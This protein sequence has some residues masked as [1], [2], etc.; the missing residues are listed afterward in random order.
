MV[1]DPYE[2]DPSKI[3]VND[4]YADLPFYGRYF[5]QDGDFHPDLE[6]IDSVDY[7]SSVLE[8]CD[9]S[10][11]LYES[12]DGG[13]D[14]FALGSVIIKASHL[15]TDAPRRNYT[16]ADANEVAAIKLV[17]D[18]LRKADVLVPNIYFAGKVGKIERTILA[19]LSRAEANDL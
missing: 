10:N 15:R 4:L 19:L 18:V 11:C 8:K 2:A 14:V 17:K 7:W 3:P 6:Q 9:A 1:I 16:I 13:R 12:I 5:P